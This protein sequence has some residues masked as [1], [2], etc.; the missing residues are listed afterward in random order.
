VSAI[1]QDIRYALRSFLR[2]PGFTA[3]ALL[4]LALGIGGTTA[5]FSIVDGVVLRPLPYSDS[6]RIVRLVRTNALG[7][8]ES[9]SAPDFLD[10]KKGATY[11]SA[12]AGYRSDVIDLTGRAEPVRVKGM[13]TTAAFFDIFDAPPLF[14][15]TYHEASDTPGSAIAVIGESIWRQQFGSDPKVV[16]SVVRLNGKPTEIIGV[17]PARVRHPHNTDVWTLAPTDVPTSPL[18]PA[19]DARNV[20]YFTAV[21]RIAGDRSLTDAREQIRAVGARVAAETK[22][23]EGASSLDVQPLAASMVANVRTALLIVLGAVAFVLLIACANV[24]GLLVARGAAR[25]REIAVRTALGAGRGRLIRQLL[26]ESLVLAV[27]GGVSGLLV[28]YWA[29]QLLI[30]AA[31]EN[32]PRLDDV[33]LDWRIALFAFAATLAVGVLFGLAPSL[34]ASKPELNADLKDGGRTGTARTGARNV[35]VVAQ[36]ALALVLLIGAGLMLTSFARLRAVDPGFRTTDL[37]TVELMLPLARYDEQAQ[38]RFYTSVLERLQANP[39]TAQSAIMFPFPFGGGNAQAG[40]QV[41]GQPRKPPPDRVTAEL[42]AISPGY[43]Q[44]AGLRLLSGRDFAA[45]DGPGSPLV[46]LISEATVKEFGGKNPIGEQIDLGSPATVVG[47]VSDARRRSLDQPPRPA[48]Y[49]P[50][51]RFMLPYMGAMIRTDRG[52]AAITPAVKAVVAQLDPDLPIGD[53]HTIEQIIENSTGEPRFRSFLI[54]GFAGLAL[55]LAAVGVYGLISF[56]VTQRVPEIGVRLALGASPGQV[57]RQVIGQ[58]LRLAVAGV[59]LGLVAAAAATR[60]LQG[61]L[62]NTS[63]TEPAIYL[64]LSALLLAMAVLACYVPARRAM[65]VDPMTALRSE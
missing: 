13:E 47:I 23:E 16:G 7:D 42:N 6:S 36:V 61:L 64:S 49:L 62:F 20:S 48:V 29:L 41:I 28:A 58:G 1:G 19:E 55:L 50:Y 26:T 65:R 51:T 54:A 12:V 9:F 57:F 18:G 34:S 32:M 8:D 60:L 3:V 33:T 35:M 11:L 22:R 21:A 39:V 10:F 46:A 63:A 44:T 43:L 37:V 2:A 17:V 14:G 56:M 24:A 31:P 30:G 59:V 5:I 45:T 53:V 27:A 15:R 4:T 52:A 38:I 25:R 40:L